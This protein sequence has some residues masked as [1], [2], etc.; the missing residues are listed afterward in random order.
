[1]LYS[2][3]PVFFFESPRKNPIIESGLLQRNLL[4]TIRDNKFISQ[5][6]PGSNFKWNG[7]VLLAIIQYH[8]SRFFTHQLKIC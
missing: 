2:K 5:R 1:M 8:F 3:N 4:G 6:I 7:N